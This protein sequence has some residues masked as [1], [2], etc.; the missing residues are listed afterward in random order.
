MKAREFWL[1]FFPS[2]VDA[3]KENLDRATAYVNGLEAAGGTEML[4]ALE[5]ALRDQGPVAQGAIRQVVFLTDG[6]IGNEEQ[7]FQAIA[8]DRGNARVFTVGIGSAPNSF[9]MAKAAEIGRG[10][11]THIGSENQVAERMGEPVGAADERE[12]ID[13]I[14]GLVAAVAG[15]VPARGEIIRLSDTLEAEVIDADPRKVKRLK[16][17]RAATPAGD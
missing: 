4:P 13:T 14:G 10:T 8:A 16:L 1:L 9:F 12:D 7:L 2:L 3:S 6:A 11:Y 5:A 17:R 15:R